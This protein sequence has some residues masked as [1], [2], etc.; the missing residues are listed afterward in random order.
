M[1]ANYPG[2]LPVKDP[3]GALLSSNPHSAL[4]DKMYDEIVAIATELGINANGTAADVGARIAAIES[5][6]WTTSTGT[7]V[8]QGATTNISKT[9]NFARW[10]ALR[11]DTFRLFQFKYTMSGSGTAGSDI[12]VFK[13][14]TTLAS[15]SYTG[16]VCVYN[17]GGV[18]YVC[19]AWGTGT[20]SSGGFN[21]RTETTSLGNLG[22][23]PNLAIASGDVIQGFILDAG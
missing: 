1:A 9:V 17:D 6:A 16:G 2:S 10:I 22:T 5:G 3:A 20:G 19:D 8:D 23:V 14:W 7:Q 11:A 12:K 4:H 21:L 15:S 18:S 13:P